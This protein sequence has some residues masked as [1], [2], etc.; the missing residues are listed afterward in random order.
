[1]PTLLVGV[2]HHCAPLELRERVA[3]TSESA[4]EVLVHLVAQSH[5]EEALLLSTCNRTEVYLRHHDEQKAFQRGLDL[6]FLDRAK[7]VKEEGRFY[8]KHGTEAARHL[9]SVATGLE[10]MVLGEPEILGQVK[11]AAAL[12][13]GI[14]TSG[15]ILRR[16]ARSAAT[17]G[18]RARGETAIGEGAVSFGY[19]T[20]DLARSIFVNLESSSVL[21]LGAGETSVKVARSLIEKGARKVQIANRGQDRADA[22]L[23]E[24]SL[25]SG[26][27]FD[28]RLE[29][30]G[31]ADLVVA[32][33]SA[34]EA[35]LRREDV[36][37]SLRHRKNR[38]LLIV[39]LGVPRDVDPAVGN[40]ANVFLHDIDSLEQLIERNLKRRRQEV[41]RVS[42]ILE[43]ELERL[44]IWYASL[45]A[46]PLVA[47]LHRRAE[48]IR[49]REIADHH[50]HF[51]ES[52]HEHL[53]NLTRSIVRKI[54]HHPS[55][56][57]REASSTENLHHLAALK[58]LFR[59]DED[60]EER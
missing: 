11:Q 8:V 6:V 20:V 32:A 55:S 21:I 36:E 16:L 40:L 27:A 19:A 1:M 52:T 34:P 28:R 53:A 23:Q 29:A 59:L 18:R 35:I 10:S 13:E 37:Q 33:T 22:F 38:P 49:A 48:E 51:P 45:A 3:Y 26:V 15:V 54:L 58:D 39:D 56:Q 30:L 17:A 12:A 43:E 50:H 24:F 4:E 42:Q 46:A 60:D 5:I 41:P 57:L 31:D 44:Q 7:E 47:Q 14:G 2:D 25:A 9:L